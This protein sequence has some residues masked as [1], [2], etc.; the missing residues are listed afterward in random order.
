[1]K[2]FANIV[3]LVL[4]KK[5]YIDELCE[6]YGNP[7]DVRDHLLLIANDSRFLS[8]FLRKDIKNL[9][10]EV[11]YRYFLFLE[12]QIYSQERQG[13]CFDCPWGNGEGGC[14]IPCCDR[15]DPDDAQVVA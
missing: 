8:H 12:S 5:K 3:K 9:D 6:H 15:S 4:C 14:T 1:M 2:N 11:E 10:K 13:G 7:Q